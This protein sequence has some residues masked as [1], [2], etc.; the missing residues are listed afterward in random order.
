M[1]KEDELPPLSPDEICIKVVMV[2]CD[3]TQIGKGIILFSTRYG[4]NSVIISHALA[5]VQTQ[6]FCCRCKVYVG[7]NRELGS[8]WLLT[9]V[10][11]AGGGHAGFRSLVIL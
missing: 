1:V 4:S 10:D 7:N 6:S 9:I 2:S 11:L 8:G 5:C 3:P